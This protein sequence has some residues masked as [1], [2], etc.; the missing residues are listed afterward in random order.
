MISP[1][2]FLIAVATTLSA[3]PEPVIG[4]I[5]SGLHSI[6]KN[7]HASKEYG[8]PTDLTRDLLPIPVHSHNDYWRDRP[9]Y[10]GLSKGCTSTEADVWLYNGTLYVGHDE[11]ALTY[12]RTLENLYINPILDVLDRQNPDSPFLTAP[13]KNGVWDT[14]TAQTLYFFIDVKTSGHET[15]KAVI[16]AL[17]PLREKG[18]LTKLKGGKT[19]E[20]GP[21]TIIGTGDTPLDMILPV[22][23]RDYFFD[24]PLA[25]LSE[26][27][28]SRIDYRVSPIASTDFVKAVGKVAIDTEPV[29]REEQ[30]KSLRAQISVARERGI[31]ARYW[32]TPNWPVRQRNLV[33]RTLL[34]EGVGLLN[35]D[36]LDAVTTFF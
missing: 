35:A 29:L 9:F 21:V 30:L 36:D 24:A 25:D 20:T 31:G 23:D 27:K 17:E 12:E 3:A 14:D 6:L 7:T 15:F 16:K 34:Q 5:T 11:S 1:L 18:Y 22:M 13:T 33:W 26:S 4:S 2:L 28:Y 32:N 10:T 8:Y 19:V